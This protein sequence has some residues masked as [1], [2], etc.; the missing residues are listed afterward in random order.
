MPVQNFGG[1]PKNN[2][3]GQKHAKFGPISDDFELWRRISAERMKI[4]QN[5]Q[6]Y[7]LP[8]FFP[9]LVKKVG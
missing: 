3:W 1:P 2:F 8:R 4:F 9:H 7:D 6:V 5:G